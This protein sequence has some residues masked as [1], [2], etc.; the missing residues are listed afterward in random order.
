LFLFSLVSPGQGDDNLAIL[1]ISSYELL[2]HGSK[3]AQ[4]SGKCNAHLGATIMAV[5]I[6]PVID[7]E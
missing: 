5:T 6:V 3:I 7:Y 2:G 4:T 1:E